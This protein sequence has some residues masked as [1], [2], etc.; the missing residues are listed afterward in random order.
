MKI[1]KNFLVQ[2]TKKTASVESTQT[3]EEKPS[4]FSNQELSASTTSSQA[5]YLGNNSLMTQLVSS[6]SDM[7]ESLSNRKI[8]A[9]S[10][11]AMSALSKATGI[12]S[13]VT[14]KIQSYSAEYESILNN[15][16]LS[17]SEKRRKL[18][19][20][21][22]KISACQQEGE[23]KIE[24]LVDFTSTLSSL[25]QVFRQCEKAGISTNEI[26][27]MLKQIISNINT[28]PSDFSNVKNSDDVEEFMK[29]SLSGLLGN[30][31]AAK[32]DSY[33]AEMEQ[34]IS[35]NESELKT[36][37]ITKE[38]ENKLKLENIVYKSIKSLLESFKNNAW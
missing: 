22:A 35:K 17:E 31:T 4:S 11:Q 10:A 13:A 1:E 12:M 7:A 18:E 33:I 3:Q 26:S 9:L 15:P 21:E 28:A 34:K 38:E 2:Q 6:I 23:S 24:A 25:V 36:A 20:L 5:E 27:S 30:N 37:G 29:T 32:L 14:L 8:F 19:E 16:Y